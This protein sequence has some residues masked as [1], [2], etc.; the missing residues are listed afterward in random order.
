MSD[1]N[2]GLDLF[3]VFAL[4]DANQFHLGNTFGMWAFPDESFYRR[5]YVVSYICLCFT[6]SGLLQIGSLFSIR[7]PFRARGVTFFWLAVVFYCHGCSFILRCV[8]LPDGRDDPRVRWPITQGM[9]WFFT[10]H[11]H[12]T[13][14]TPLLHGGMLGMNRRAYATLNIVMIVLIIL[15]GPR[16]VFMN[17]NAHNF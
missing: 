14:L 4:C 2:A 11:T 13:L 12:M 8:G 3:R 1:R 6:M 16:G 5:Y 10:A 17:E 15:S 9:S 7:K